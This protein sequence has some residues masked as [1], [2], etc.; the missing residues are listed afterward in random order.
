MQILQ[1]CYK[2]FRRFRI[3]FSEGYHVQI[4]N[5]IRL[6]VTGLLKCIKTRFYYYKCVTS[7]KQNHFSSSTF[8]FESKIKQFHIKQ[9][10]F[11]SV[12]STYCSN[13][14]ARGW[15]WSSTRNSGFRCRMGCSDPRWRHWSSHLNPRPR[16]ETSEC[17]SSCQCAN[18]RKRSLW[19]LAS[20]CRNSGYLII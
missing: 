4:F 13:L 19:K 2:N 20:W 10:I 14:S 3:P 7:L 9:D 6:L 1:I 18:R 17:S 16:G 15:S 8:L 11:S 5:S 12:C